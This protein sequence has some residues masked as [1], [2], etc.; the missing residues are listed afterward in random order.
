[1]KTMVSKKVQME[2]RS[3]ILLLLE[4][5]RAT[6]TFTLECILGEHAQFVTAL[7]CTVQVAAWSVCSSFVIFNILNGP[8]RPAN[9]VCNGHTFT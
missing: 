8:S 7:M 5:G 2:S 6:F 9:G 1:M 4:I 3:R